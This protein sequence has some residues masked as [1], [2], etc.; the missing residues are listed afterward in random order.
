M[1]VEVKDAEKSQKELNI[2]VPVEKYN[3]MYDAE[4]KKIV[5]TVKIPGFRKG[6][7][8]KSVV[9]KEYSHKVRVNA[10]EKVINNS[11][12]EACLLYTS[13]SPRDRTRSR[14]PSSA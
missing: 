3:E 10:L 8:P 7:A 9:E 2:E 12:Y 11:V 13:P 4:L 5:P 14:M 6:K 1:K